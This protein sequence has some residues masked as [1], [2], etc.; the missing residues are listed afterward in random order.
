VNVHNG[1]PPAPNDD[2]TPF[3]VGGGL[4]AGLPRAQR[5]TK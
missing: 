3:P 2:I 4:R 1:R 5:K